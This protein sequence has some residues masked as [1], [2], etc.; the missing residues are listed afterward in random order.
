LDKSGL[1]GL[2]QVMS[3]GSCLY[4][5]PFRQTLQVARRHP[6]R[7]RSPLPPMTELRPA[8]AWLLQC[9]SRGFSCRIGG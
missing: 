2:R 4:P 7:N 6:F 5:T 9:A 1:F 8:S 3:R